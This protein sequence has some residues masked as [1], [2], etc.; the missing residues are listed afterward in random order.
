M[1]QLI[2]I[3]HKRENARHFLTVLNKRHDTG[4]RTLTGHFCML[5]EAKLQV[6]TLTNELHEQIGLVADLLAQLLRRGEVH[7]ALIQK[8]GTLIVQENNAVELLRKLRALLEGAALLCPPVRG[9]TDTIISGDDFDTPARLPSLATVDEE[10]Q[11]A[12]PAF[13]DEITIQ[14][15]YYYAEYFGPTRP[16]CA[17]PSDSDVELIPGIPGMS[18]YAS[19]TT[20][21]DLYAGLYGDSEPTIG[22]VV[23]G[24]A[25]SVLFE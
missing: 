20:T 3:T 23:C 25:E 24:I 22:S 11:H 14:P 13:L 12:A 21:M 6:C 18:E 1:S 10:A 19:T 9:L 2:S 4:H 17:I 16:A 7:E 8:Y 15:A 5:K